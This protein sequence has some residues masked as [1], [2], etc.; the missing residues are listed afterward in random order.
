MRRPKP[1]ELWRARELAEIVVVDAALEVLREVLVHEH[2]TLGDLGE[3]DPPTTLAARRLLETITSLRS[4]LRRY[5]AAVL[6]PSDPAAD[7]LPF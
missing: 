3:T 2:P 1:I 7:K 5:R 6:A 4:Q